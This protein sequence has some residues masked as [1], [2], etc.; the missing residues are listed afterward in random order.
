VS[1]ALEQ[2]V[3]QMNIDLV[4]MTTHGRGGLS[5][6]WLGSVADTLVRNIDVPVLL[7][8]SASV[9]LRGFG[10]QFSVTNILVPVDGTGFSENVIEQ[11]LALGSLL[12]ARYTLVQVVAPPIMA[13]LESAPRSIDAEFDVL[14][15]HTLAS[16]E[17]LA[18][19]MRARGAEVST[20]VVV[21]PQAAAG[22][23]EYAI[24]CRADLIAMAT[25]GRTG[26][27]RMA[28]GSVAD[29]VMRATQMPLLLMRPTAESFAE[30]ARFDYEAPRWSA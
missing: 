21:Q 28:L 18:D 7:L 24:E 15:A 20:A 13:A 9:E 11:A 19:R 6:V 27:T 23:L 3:E 22:I 8:R 16:L 29:K 25:H 17:Q 4:I 12:N 14:R 1:E 26:W 10:P 5:R 2:Y 30:Q